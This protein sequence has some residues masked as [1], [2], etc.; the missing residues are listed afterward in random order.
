MNGKQAKKIRKLLKMQPQA[1]EY[2]FVTTPGVLRNGLMV[3]GLQWKFTYVSADKRALY[4]M[5]K[6][7]ARLVEK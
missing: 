3:V 5:A 7:M 1:T 2:K 4:K 6:K